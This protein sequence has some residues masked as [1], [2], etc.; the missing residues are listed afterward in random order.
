LTQSSVFAVA[1]LDGGGSYG[2]R[3]CGHYQ[4]TFG[5]AG[6]RIIPSQPIAI[7]SMD[8]TLCIAA[9]KKQKLIYILIYAAVMRLTISSPLEAHKSNTP[10]LLP[11]RAR[12]C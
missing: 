8:H 12:V 5:K 9:L 1:G 3:V 10:H 7:D 2:N 11:H 6:R 4:E